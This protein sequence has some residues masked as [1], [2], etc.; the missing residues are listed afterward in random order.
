ME[1]AI[2]QRGFWLDATGDHHRFDQYLAHALWF[3]F[4]GSSVLDLGCGRGEYV[5]FFTERGISASGFDGNPHTQRWLPSAGVVDMS[6]SQILPVHDWVLTLEVGEHIP[7]AYESAFIQNLHRHNRK[8]IILSWA[9][10]G[11]KGW[12]HVNC[13]TNEEVAEKVC[14]LGYFRDIEAEKQLRSA[15]TLRWFKNTLMVF[16]REHV[17]GE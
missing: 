10:P 12:G 14:P 11:Q 17:T 15:A 5:R 4:A 16:P 1:N 7:A 3:Y 9:V 13:K 8:G 2:H 6:T